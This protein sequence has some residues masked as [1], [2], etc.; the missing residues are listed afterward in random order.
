M[1]LVVVAVSAGAGLVLRKKVSL[2]VG[3]VSLALG[4]GAFVLAVAVLWVTIIGWGPLDAWTAGLAA[5]VL[6]GVASLALPFALAVTL[7]RSS[8]ESGEV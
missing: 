7:G 6:L 4:L 8:A 2:K 5:V 1:L 3:R